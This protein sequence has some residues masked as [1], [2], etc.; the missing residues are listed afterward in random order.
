MIARAEKAN[1]VSNSR[2]QACNCKGTLENIFPD[3]S[4][5]I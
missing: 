2:P 1:V 3:V 4:G 5:N